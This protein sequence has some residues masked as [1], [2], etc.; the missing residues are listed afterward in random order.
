VA[1]LSPCDPCPPRKDR[2]IVTQRGFVDT[3][4]Q[5]QTETCFILTSHPYD[6]TAPIG[7]NGPCVLYGIAILSHSPIHP[8]HFGS[9]CGGL[10]NA[11]RRRRRRRKKPARL[12][13]WP[14]TTGN[15]SVQIIDF[16]STDF[17]PSRQESVQARDEGRLTIPTF[18]QMP[19][20]DF[21]KN[22]NF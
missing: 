17:A 4:A 7:T 10:I 9:Y 6:A 12:S 8:S 19:C 13:T 15:V 20:G 14:C 3:A 2:H 16:V 1:S 21:F 22:C 11:G 5:T 18:E